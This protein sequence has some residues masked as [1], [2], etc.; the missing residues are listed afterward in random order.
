MIRLYIHFVVYG[1]TVE[2]GFAEN[3]TFPQCLKLLERMH[4]AEL[5]EFHCT[6][7]E[8]FYLSQETVPLNPEETLHKLGMLSGME[9]EVI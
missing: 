8:W 6:G 1:P 7:E 9:I 4:L 3:L 2:C 5:E